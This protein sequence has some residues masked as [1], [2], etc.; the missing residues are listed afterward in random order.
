MVCKGSAD[1]GL[2]RT[3]AAAD[4]AVGRMD[5]AVATLGGSHAVRMSTNVVRHRSV[6][7]LRP[8]GARM[9]RGVGC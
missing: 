8:D 7:R 4:R 3:C 2:G 9:E 5:M 1:R 6:A